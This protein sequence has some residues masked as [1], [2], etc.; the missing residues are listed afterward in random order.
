[1]FYNIKK[2]VEVKNGEFSVN[3]VGKEFKILFPVSGDDDNKNGVSYTKLFQAIWKNEGITDMSK[4]SSFY[5]L[6]KN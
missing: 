6:N 3:L 5:P 2:C 4:M 1:M